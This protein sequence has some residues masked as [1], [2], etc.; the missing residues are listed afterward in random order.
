MAKANLH[1]KTS[2]CSCCTDDGSDGA[3]AW[4]KT[5]KC[6]KCRASRCTKQECRRPPEHT[7]FYLPGIDA[8][9]GWGWY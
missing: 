7:P 9:H 1:K 5:G 8:P 2:C 4:N 3:K 6:N